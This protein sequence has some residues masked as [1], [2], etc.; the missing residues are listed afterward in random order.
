MR[1][2]LGLLTV[3]V[4]LI[5]ALPVSAERLPDIFLGFTPDTTPTQ[6]RALLGSPVEM[7]VDPLGVVTER[8]AIGNAATA[9]LQWGPNGDLWGVTVYADPDPAISATSFRSAGLTDPTYDILMLSRPQIVDR[10]GLVDSGDPSRVMLVD[11]PDDPWVM[12]FNWNDPMDRSVSWYSR[13]GVLVQNIPSVTVIE[14]QPMVVLE[15]PSAYESDLLQSGSSR[16]ETA[17]IRRAFTLPTALPLRLSGPMTIFGVALGGPL[18]ADRPDLGMPTSPRPTTD[19]VLLS[20]SPMRLGEDFSV[21]CNPS[22]GMAVADR[23]NTVVLMTLDLSR[24]EEAK[25]EQAL[26]A[27]VGH[28]TNS[29]LY[30]LASTRPELMAHTYSAGWEP[31]GTQLALPFRESNGIEGLLTL[32]YDLDSGRSYPTLI[33]IE[34]R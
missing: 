34:R 32:K 2:R 23:A 26:L 33:V 22:V 19:S 11:S 6:A 14:T 8:Y 4:L 17:D 10:Y 21:S 20:Y 18:D 31:M 13:G 30:Q 5:T 24:L 25:Q 9:A 29:T 16:N 15:A 27:A 28:D 3:L 1:T 12:A 7:G